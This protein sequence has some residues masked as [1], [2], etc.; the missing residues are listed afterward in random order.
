MRDPFLFSK[1]VHLKE[2]EFFDRKE[3]FKAYFKN[4]FIKYSR[5][6]KK[7][8]KFKGFEIESV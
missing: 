2:P 8:N 5:K 6:G 4:R 1:E 7:P 3:F